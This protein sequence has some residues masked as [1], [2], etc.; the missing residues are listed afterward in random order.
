MAHWGRG[1]VAYLVIGGLGAPVF[2]YGTYGWERFTGSRAS[3]P[4]PSQACRRVR[5]GAVPEHEI[6]VD[7]R[8]APVRWPIH[9]PRTGLF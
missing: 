3:S 8:L 6:R 5:H 7:R 4:F 2:S 1:R 9:Y